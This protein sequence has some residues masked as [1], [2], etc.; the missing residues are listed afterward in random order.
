MSSAR[1]HSGSGNAGVR[2][3]L[4]GMT[5]AGGV[6]NASAGIAAKPPH[7]AT[8]GGRATRGRLLER[9]RL[10]DPPAVRP[11][12]CLRACRDHRPAQLASLAGSGRL[13][14][15][16]SQPGPMFFACLH[17]SIAVIIEHSEV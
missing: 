7:G 14:V 17:S 5:V 15:V 10:V 9:A 1:R 6:V 2:R 4:A 11:K 12:P 3:H 16:I 8:A 13:V